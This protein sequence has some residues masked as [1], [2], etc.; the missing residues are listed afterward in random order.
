METTQGLTFRTAGMKL[1]GALFGGLLAFIVAE[2]AKGSV[3]IS[4]GLTAPVGLIIGYLLLHNKWSKAGT[5]CAL[6]YNL[7]LGVATVF[8]DNHVSVT[9]SRRLLTLPVGL[10][11]ATL[12][13]LVV[14]PY[15]SR[16]QLVLTLSSALDWMHHLVFAVEASVQFPHL[17]RKFDSI[18]YKTSHRLQLARTLLPATRY[19]VS[20]GGRRR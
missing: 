9:F 3:K 20:L 16:S 8:P 18:V 19:E 6:A 7:I 17:E 2:I 4:I 5:V 13:H 11:V 1:I 14:Y 10:A 12:V 15:H